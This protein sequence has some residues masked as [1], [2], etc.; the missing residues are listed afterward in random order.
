MPVNGGRQ[1]QPLAGA[2]VYS[3]GTGDVHY[4]NDDDIICCCCLTP[5]L[6]FKM[7]F[8]FNL[9]SFCNPISIVA[10]LY[11]IPWIREDN[12]KTRTGLVN[13]VRMIYCVFWVL[14]PICALAGTV[15]LV[16]LII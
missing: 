5:E 2:Q 3:V 8:I 4:M 16:L 1:Y 6:G 14:T 11:L 13:V 15:V 12:K 10:L 9:F 7:L